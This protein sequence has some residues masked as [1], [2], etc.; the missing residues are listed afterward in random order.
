MGLFTHF[1]A[2]SIR[3]ALF[4]PL[5]ELLGSVGDHVGQP[6]NPLINKGEVQVAIVLQNL[7]NVWFRGSLVTGSN[8][9]FTK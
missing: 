4:V 3:I 7:A 8:R 1:R 2:H 6:P 9:F 5:V